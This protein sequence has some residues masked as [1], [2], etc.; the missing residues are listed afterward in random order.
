MS[1][2]DLI[3]CV[4]VLHHMR[5]PFEGFEILTSCLRRHGLM[6]IGLYSKLARSE[7]TQVRNEIAD[8]QIQSTPVEM[9]KYRSELIDSHK[10]HHKVLLNYD[11]FYNLSTF[12]DLLFNI[13]EHV[14]ELSDIKRF[15]IQMNLE[16]CG[17]ENRILNTKF[18][19]ANTNQD[20]PYDLDYWQEFERTNPKTFINMYQFW[21]QKN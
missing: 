6:K 4:G 1:S 14:F 7:I 10:P 9:K 12:R 21:C 18:T 11:D 2:Y 8:R 20:N 3:E 5:N 15:L 13:E 19:G 16:F 17:F